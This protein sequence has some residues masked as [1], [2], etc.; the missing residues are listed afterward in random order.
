MAAMT[1]WGFLGPTM[2][3]PGGVKVRDAYYTSSWGTKAKE[4][5]P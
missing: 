5:I 2:K 3:E 4:I 1:K